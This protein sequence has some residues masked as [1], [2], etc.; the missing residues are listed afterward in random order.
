MLVRLL[1]LL[2]SLVILDVNF[3]LGGILDLEASDF[4]GCQD[5]MVGKYG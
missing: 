5:F 4:L 3:V 1:R 2:C